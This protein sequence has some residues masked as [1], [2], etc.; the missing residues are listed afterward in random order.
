[1]LSHLIAVS[2][3]ARLL[4]SCF[5]VPIRFGDDLEQLVI[6]QFYHENNRYALLE[7][8]MHDELD[9]SRFVFEQKVSTDRVHAHAPKYTRSQRNTCG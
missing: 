7:T 8:L 2:R 5:P 6:E 4:V 3:V 1:M 9:N